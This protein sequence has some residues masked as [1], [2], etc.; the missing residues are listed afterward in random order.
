[1]NLL[2]I[3]Y[4]KMGKAI[5]EIAISRGHTIVGKINSSTPLSSILGQKI[6]CA[7]EFTRP[8]LAAENIKFC[9]E[10]QIP[11]AVGTTGW[12]EN[13]EE[14]KKYVLENN[15]TMLAATNFSMGV[16]ITFHINKILASVMSKFPEYQ[17]E[18]TEIHHT[19]KLDAPSGTAITIAEGIVEKH[20]V[21][22][23]FGLASTNNNASTLPIIALR[24]GTVPGTHIVKYSSAI[25]TIT[26]TH[27]AHNRT[28]FALGSILAAEWL[29]DKKGVFTMTDMLGF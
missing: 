6:D 17:A 24:E 8:E 18:I 28:G 9:A 20:T 12:Y 2:L 13:Y 11:V 16:N 25:D 15:G 7:I 29:L 27:E 21:Y 3:G 19:Q 22:N 10:H 14:L 4:G 26:L 1:M 23:D 5:E